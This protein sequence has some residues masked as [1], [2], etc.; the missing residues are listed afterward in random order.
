MHAGDKGDEGGVLSSAGMLC[1]L[2]DDDT[3]T[4]CAR[5]VV[6][7][8][9]MGV[10]CVGMCLHAWCAVV[11]AWCVH[12]DAVHC[13]EI[14]HKGRGSKD[15]AWREGFKDITYTVRH[16]HTC[17]L[18]PTDQGCCHSLQHPPIHINIGSPYKACSGRPLPCTTWVLGY[19]A[20]AVTP[21]LLQHWHV[22]GVCH[23]VYVLHRIY[24]LMSREQLS[25]F[26]FVW[27]LQCGCGHG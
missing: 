15:I 4:L 27:V 5:Y 10:V 17:C 8:C 20:P 11:Y 16:Q 7:G 12:V 2:C 23:A 21:M 3:V 19:I 6:V 25:R 22:H 1:T 13:T 24:L 14:L 18:V 9:T 26:R